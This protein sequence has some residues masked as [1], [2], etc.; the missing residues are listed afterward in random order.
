MPYLVR[1]FILKVINFPISETAGWIIDVLYSF[2]QIDKTTFTSTTKAYQVVYDKSLS[3][4]I[5]D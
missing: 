4:I 1:A 3:G 2:L 5:I